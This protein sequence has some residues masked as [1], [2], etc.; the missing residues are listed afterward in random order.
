MQMNNYDNW[1]FEQLYEE[2]LRRGILER[3][4]E[5]DKCSVHS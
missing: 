3:E 1:T 5:N 4:G 2:C